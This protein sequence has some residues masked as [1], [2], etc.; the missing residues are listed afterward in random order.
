MFHLFILHVYNICRDSDF[1]DKIQNSK[2][3]L[4]T[5]NSISK[6]FLCSFKTQQYPPKTLGSNE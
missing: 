3:N 6:E 5:N 1:S 4:I 2:A